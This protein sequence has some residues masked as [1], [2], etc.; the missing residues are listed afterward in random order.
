MTRPSPASTAASVMTNAQLILEEGVVAGTLVIEGDRIADVQPG[1]SN[2]PGA[3]DLNGDFLGPGLIEIHTDNVE[4][5]FMPRPKVYWPNGLAAALAH[6]AQITAAGITTVFDAICAGGVDSAREFRTYIFETAIDALRQGVRA[7]VF[8]ADHRLHLRCELSAPDVME[9]V[10]AV[11]EEPLLGLVSLMDHTPG[12]RQF[13]D[14]EKLRAFNTAAGQTPAEADRSFA[15]R[16]AVGPQLVARNWPKVLQLFAG[17]G[18]PLASHDDTTEEHVTLAARSGI[19]ISEFPTTEVAARMAHAHG[20]ATV[21]GG[22]NVV[23]GGS[24]SGNVAA[25][26]L[27]R[28]GLLDCLSSDYVPASLLQAAVRLASDLDRPLNQTFGFVSWRVADMVGLHD[29]GRLEPG[30]RADL[31]RFRLLGDTPVVREVFRSG[32]RVI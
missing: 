4:R 14:L 27:A 5:H 18:I 15:E 12:E 32:E 24:H 3:I 22:P 9:F 26:D 23:R 16:M 20:M 25:L 21:M 31:V 8:R 1:R 11:R 30:R 28:A 13:R 6:D 19:R 2:L 29:R 7:G 17:S 10:E